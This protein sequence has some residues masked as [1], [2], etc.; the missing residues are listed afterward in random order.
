MRQHRNRKKVQFAGKDYD[1]DVQYSTVRIGKLDGEGPMFDN[2]RA[3]NMHVYVAYA[4]GEVLEP[5]SEYGTPVAMFVIRVD[6]AAMV[7]K[8]VDMEDASYL[9]LVQEFI[10]VAQADGVEFD[11]MQIMHA[12]DRSTVTDTLAGRRMGTT[13]FTP[14][15]LVLNTDFKAPDV[16]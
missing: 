16:L 15:D 12:V 8:M 9:T 10:A 2:M 1:V 11:P 6:Q 14:D 4:Q 5:V 7:T 13:K 3:Q